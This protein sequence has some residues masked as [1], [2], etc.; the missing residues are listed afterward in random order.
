MDPP[1][2]KIKSS[3]YIDYLNSTF[4]KVITL[5]WSFKF[6]KIFNYIFYLYLIKNFI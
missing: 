2:K 3:N 5:I 1:I 6:Q 4:K